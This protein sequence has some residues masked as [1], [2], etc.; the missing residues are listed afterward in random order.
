MLIS[1]RELTKNETMK[2]GIHAPV[3][4]KYPDCTLKVPRYYKSR[5]R[6]VMPRQG[7]LLK[8]WS[9]WPKFH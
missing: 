2:I 4:S 7:A 3:G 5:V 9:G 8:V 6:S 1:L